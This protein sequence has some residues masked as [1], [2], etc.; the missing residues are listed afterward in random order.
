MV[1][2][3]GALPGV[4]REQLSAFRKP[5]VTPGKGR[6]REQLL[7]FPE[8]PRT[9]LTGVSV[10]ESRMDLIWEPG[11]PELVLRHL[12]LGDSKRKMRQEVKL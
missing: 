11:L 3:M 6:S 12:P 7:E 9:D 5:Q 2:P 1:G 8:C 4:E 10:M